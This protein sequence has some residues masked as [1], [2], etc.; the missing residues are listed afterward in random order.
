MTQNTLYDSLMQNGIQKEDAE[1]LSSAFS[2]NGNLQDFMEGLERIGGVLALKTSAHF[3]GGDKPKSEPWMSIYE[4]I[5][6]EVIQ[7]NTAPLVAFS[8]ALA[9][10][11]H[12]WDLQQAI[13]N[14]AG[15]RMGIIQEL[16]Q[17]KG[18]RKVYQTKDYI[19]A[20]KKLGYTFRMRELDNR[21]ELNGNPIEDHIENE[22][23]NSMVDHGFQVQMTIRVISEVAGKN[24]Y[25]PIKNYL[26]SLTHDGGNYIEELASYFSDVYGM[27]PVWLRKWLIGAVAKVYEAA[28]NPMLVLDGPQGIGKSE[29][30]RWLAS[31]LTEYYIESPINT[32]DKDCYIRLISNW[33]WEVS[34]L[35][36]TTRKSDY[37]ALKAFLTTRKVTVRKPY[38]KGDI[39]RPALASFI[40]TINNSS[41]IF[42]D[43]TGSRRFLTSRIPTIVW[44]YSKDLEPDQIWAEAMAAYK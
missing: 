27:F 42:S 26:D 22:I 28:Q 11:E 10:W 8:Q 31:P 34:E 14:A 37:E 18:Q 2:N 15:Y 25:H 4:Y 7:N 17:K 38:G 21:I 20:L 33:I 36:T 41:G 30:V 24:K 23:V 3:K 19:K 44:D 13:S 5:A 16:E 35:G 6:L 29:F 43:P 9:A 32:N 40:G 39:E 1:Q 12:D